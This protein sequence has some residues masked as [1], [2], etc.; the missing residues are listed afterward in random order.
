MQLDRSDDGFVV[1]LTLPDSPLTT[2]TARAVSEAC[3]ALIDD[4]QVRVVVLTAAGDFSSEPAADFDPVAADPDPA[5]ALA[6]LRV[7]VIAAIGGSCDGFG[8][9]L[10][11]ACDIRVA[12]ADA[13]FSVDHVVQGRLPAWGLTQRLP[14]AVGAARATSMLLLGSHLGAREAAAA[15]VVHDVV[16]DLDA[17]VERLLELLRGTG[18]LALEF[19]KEAVHRGSE[20]PLRDGLRLEGDLNHQLAVTEDRADQNQEILWKPLIGWLVTSFMTSPWV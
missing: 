1:T 20:L 7:P 19:A 5:A 17:E 15:G 14:R 11:L 10:L 4:R 9:A 18:P 8:L 3:T 6:R 12:H 13:V 2:A 16:D